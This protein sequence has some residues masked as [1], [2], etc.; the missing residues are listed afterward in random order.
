MFHQRVGA[1]IQDA[2]PSGQAGPLPFFKGQT[3]DFGPLPDFALIFFLNSRQ[4]VFISPSLIYHLITYLRPMGRRA[5]LKFQ[6]NSQGGC[7][8]RQKINRF[9]MIADSDRL[10]T[11]PSCTVSAV[12]N[13]KCA[14]PPPTGSFFANSVQ[15]C[16]SKYGIGDNRGPNLGCSAS[17]KSFWNAIF[18]V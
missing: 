4:S 10:H 13:R 12:W 14:H 6:L 17:Q 7:T 8:G 9:S 2:C 3:C 11:S 1:L 18:L 15:D 16:I 5:Y